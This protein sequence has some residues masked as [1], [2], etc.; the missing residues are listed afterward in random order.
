V[1]PCGVFVSKTHPFLAAS[2]HG[3]IKEKDKLIE[4]K[5]PFTSKN[6]KITSETV[7]YLKTVNDKMVLDVTHDYFYQIQGQLFCCQKRECDLIVYTFEDLKIITIERN[8]E[9]IKEMVEKLQGFFDTFFKSAVLD[10]MYFKQYYRYT[11]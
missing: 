4:V 11:F 10:K 5:C 3:L 7:P 6:K 1:T 8:E 2:P 9:F